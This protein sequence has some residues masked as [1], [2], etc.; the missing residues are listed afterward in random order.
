MNSLQAY[1]LLSKGVHTSSDLLRIVSSKMIYSWYFLALAV[2]VHW[3]TKKIPLH[4]K[5]FFRW[6]SLHL[7]T[8]FLS[9]FLHQLLS[10]W[11]D[12]F[13]W[14]REEKA[15]VFYTLFNNPSVW[16]EILVYILFLLGISLVES[17][18]IRRENEILLSELEVQLVQSK[19]HVLRSKIHP[20]FVFN[21]LRTISE[22]LHKNRN[23]DANHVLALMSEFFRTMVYDSEQEEIT[24]AEEIRFLNR[25]FEIQQVSYKDDFLVKEDIDHETLDA[26]VPNFIL[27]PLVE[28]L[29]CRIDVR[30]DFPYEIMLWTRKHTDILEIHIE[31]NLKRIHNAQE[32][33][34]AN[35][36]VY[37]ILKERLAQLYG[38]DQGLQFDFRLERGTQVNIRIPFHGATMESEIMVLLENTR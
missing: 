19:L 33:Q 26:L 25:Y 10:L 5:Y 17:R 3:L 21:T 20:Q 7:T 35:G 4:R 11:A 6:L 24:L 23:N 29:V 30:Y 32:E 31:D 15:M 16:I 36:S 38:N 22:L 2:V 8:L 27:Q 1:Y 9:F 18:R 34:Y 14:G 13:I 12:R 37:S 28:D